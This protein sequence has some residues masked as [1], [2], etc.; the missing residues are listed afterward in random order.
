MRFLVVALFLM[1]ISCCLATN[2]KALMVEGLELGQRRLGDNEKP[3]LGQHSSGSTVD[4]HHYI[5]RE[6][7]NNFSGGTPTPIPEE[8]D[9]GNGGN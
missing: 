8:G 3:D 4:N 2:R 6:D 1:T 7:F 5:S 9:S